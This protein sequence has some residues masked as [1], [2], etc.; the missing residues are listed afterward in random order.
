MLGA[1]RRGAGASRRRRP[2]SGY[3]VRRGAFLTGGRLSTLCAGL[4]AEHI[5]RSALTISFRG[6]KFSA[7]RAATLEGGGGF[8]LGAR[9]VEGRGETGLSHRWRGLIA[10][11]AGHNAGIDDGGVDAPCVRRGVS[12][13]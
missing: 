5:R 11:V 3:D 4:G 9:R 10:I 7:S 8:G 13:P 12:R 2:L 1:K 6:L